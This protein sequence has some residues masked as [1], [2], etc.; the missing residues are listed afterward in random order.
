[1]PLKCKS[2]TLISNKNLLVCYITSLLWKYFKISGLTKT[3]YNLLLDVNVRHCHIVKKRWQGN[4]WTQPLSP[5]EI[6]TADSINEYISR[7]L[8]FFL[9]NIKVGI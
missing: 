8:E 4:W 7:N 3:I 5:G 1:M 6:H 2:Y 9:M